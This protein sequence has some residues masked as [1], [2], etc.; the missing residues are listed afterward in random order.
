MLPSQIGVEGSNDCSD[1][2]STNLLRPIHYIRPTHAHMHTR[3][4]AQVSGKNTVLEDVFCDV[5]RREPNGPHFAELIIDVAAVV[6]CL[7]MRTWSKKYVV[8]ISG[9]KR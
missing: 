7:T 3:T 2:Q 8:S 9:C 4:R 1:N 6:A 5:L